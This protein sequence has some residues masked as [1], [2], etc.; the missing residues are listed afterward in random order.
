[1]PGEPTKIQ[2]FANRRRANCKIEEVAAMH[3]AMVLTT[4]SSGELAKVE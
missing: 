1:M 4:P 3:F 2:R